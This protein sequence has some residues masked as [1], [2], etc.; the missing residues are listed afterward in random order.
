[1]NKEYLKRTDGSTF[2]FTPGD[3]ATPPVRGIDYWTDADQKAIVQQV[4]MELDATVYGKVNVNNVI[5]LTGKIAD[6]TYTLK[7]EDEY[8]NVKTI[9]TLNHNYE[10]EPDVPEEP[11]GPVEIPL[12]W[13][14]GVVLNKDNGRELTDPSPNYSASDYVDVD[15]AKTYTLTRDISMFNTCNVICYDASNNFVSYIN[16]SM[17]SSNITTGDTGPKS[18][19][20]TPPTNTAKIR[21]RLWYEASEDAATVAAY[22]KLIQN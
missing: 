12:T 8:G 4:L 21:L 18:A 6:G 7:Y 22:Y 2:V 3:P 16:L 11:S 14:T 19:Q 1:M 9:G 10:P 13:K 17:T 15:P 20:F 5:T